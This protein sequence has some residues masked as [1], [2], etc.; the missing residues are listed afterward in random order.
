M[1]AGDEVVPMRGWSRTIVV[2]ATVAILAL[3]GAAGGRIAAG[4]TETAFGCLVLRE[5]P[6]LQVKA[7]EEL[8]VYRQKEHRR[9]TTYGWVDQA[10]GTVHMPIEKAMEMVMERGMPV[11]K[12]APAAV[13]K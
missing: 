3:A 6:R 10:A 5:A 11:R 7:E 13:K 1:G 9:M 2:G 12:E 8:E 4:P